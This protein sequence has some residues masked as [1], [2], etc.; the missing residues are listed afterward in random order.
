MKTEFD[1][2]ARAITKPAPAV[3][4]DPATRPAIIRFMVLSFVVCLVAE[5]SKAVSI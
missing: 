1:W 2:A 5:E 4:S 3:R